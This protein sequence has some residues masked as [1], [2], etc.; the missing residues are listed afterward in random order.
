MLDEIRLM[1][2]VDE[3][4]QEVWRY[5]RAEE[6]VRSALQR[7]IREGRLVVLGHTPIP[8]GPNS[9]EKILLK[10][11][12]VV[13][14]EE[15][16]AKY[17]LY[18]DSDVK[19]H[20]RQE[21]IWQAV[22]IARWLISERSRAKRMEEELKSDFVGKSEASH[23][24][25]RQIQEA[26]FFDVNI[27]I[28]GE[29]GVG[30]GL[31]AEQIHRLSGLK[32]K[33]VSL[34][35]ASVPA[36]LFES[37]LFG[38]RRGAF[39]DAREEKRGLVEEA[40]GGTLFLDEITEM[41]LEVQGK[42]LRFVETGRFRRV[43]ETREREVHLRIISATNRPLEKALRERR[44]REDLLYR[45][46]TYQIKIPPLRERK[47]DIE[48]LLEYYGELLRG[49]KL[50]KEAL[51]LI[52]EYPFPGNVRQLMSLLQRLGMRREPLEITGEE[53]EKEL[54]LFPEVYFKDDKD[55]VALLWEKIEQGGNFWE[56]VWEPFIRRDLKR[57]EVRE[58]LRKALMKGEGSLKK[59]ALLLGVKEEEYPKFIIYLHRHEV[60]PRVK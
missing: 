36:S 2:L 33:F 44:L 22:G 1:L 39:T 54:S 56:V 23:R 11:A 6:W 9:Q 38:H 47:E 26:A 15:G 51:Y 13:P 52:R 7:G 40:A 24:I 5:G 42:L 43:G 29:T 48:A 60:H 46:S 28:E 21:E 53:V 25:R 19:E 58:F 37:E 10:T 18:F 41:P 57:S 17:F 35:C 12:V 16:E 32:G 27:L 49:R 59:A 8:A 30:K 20:F 3:E 45:L 55:E 50:T 4:G 31:V 34:N 14:V